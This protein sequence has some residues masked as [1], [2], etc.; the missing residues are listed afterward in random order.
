MVLPRMKLSD[1]IT[2]AVLCWIFFNLLWLRFLEKALSQG[3]GALL[4][5]IGAVAMVLYWPKPLEELEGDEETPAE[6]QGEGIADE[7]RE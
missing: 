1:R 2:W 5:T 7:R 3:L 4:A 6:E